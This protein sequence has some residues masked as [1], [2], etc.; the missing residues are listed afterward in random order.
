MMNPTISENHT[1]SDVNVRKIV[2]RVIRYQQPETLRDL[3]EIEI[4]DNR[5]PDNA[6]ACYKKSKRKIVI[7][8]EPILKWQPWILKKTYFFPFVMIAMTLAHELDHHMNR[9]N[10]FVNKENSASDLGHLCQAFEKHRP[11]EKQHR[12]Q[13]GHEQHGAR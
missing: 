9:D 2:E 6:F 4:V 1:E 13:H 11:A 10:D 12:R 7:Y 3:Y 8:L 5:K